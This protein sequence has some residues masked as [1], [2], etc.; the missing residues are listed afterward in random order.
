MFLGKRVQMKKDVTLLVVIAASL[1]A[2]SGG[3]TVPLDARGSATTA[4]Q[5]PL[6]E[7]MVPPHLPGESV[8]EYL[9]RVVPKIKDADVDSHIDPGITGADR[10]TIKN[11][12]L[13]LPDFARDNVIFVDRNSHIYANRKWLIDTTSI[14]APVPGKAGVFRNAEG[15]EFAGPPVTEKPGL[16]HT[17]SNVRP[18]YGTP[19][20]FTTTG[21]YRRVYSDPGTWTA[22]GMHAAFANPATNYNTV[23]PYG[24]IGYIY[25]GGWSSSGYDSAD[26]GL[27][28][29]AARN[30]ADAFMNLQ[31]SGVGQVTS[32]AHEFPPN[33]DV[34]VDFLIGC[35]SCTVG[36]GGGPYLAT[37]DWGAWTTGGYGGV[38]IAEDPANLADWTG[39]G[40]VLKAMVSLGQS[41]VSGFPNGVANDG[42]AFGYIAVDYCGWEGPNFNVCYSPP[43]YTSGY[44]L[45]QHVPDQNTVQSFVGLTPGYYEDVDIVMPGATSQSLKFPSPRP[46]ATPTPSATPTPRPRPT[47]DPCLKNP[48]LCL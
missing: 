40:V 47:V 12:M 39:N 7:M 16:R 23:G 13:G 5:A 46:G 41:G 19:P 11:V 9:S 14:A 29:S 38:T 3:G 18:M 28:Y 8:N 2:C 42:Y 32:N 34:E 17:A 36:S 31:S 25:T 37:F 33:T 1:V 44:H 48:R 15:I 43:S 21:P 30:V 45:E 24:D 26:A 35:N 27:Q 20:A 4:L 10:T 6:I 22:G